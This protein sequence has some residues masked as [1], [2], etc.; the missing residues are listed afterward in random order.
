M[1]NTFK[2]LKFRKTGDDILEVKIRDN[3]YST[4][5]KDEARI[6]NRKEMLELMI[7]LKQKGVSFPRGW[8]D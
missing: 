5:F 8:L 6:N 4:I 1:G 2:Q 7:K 3:S